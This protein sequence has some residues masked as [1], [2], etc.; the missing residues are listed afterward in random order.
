MNKLNTIMGQ[1][2]ALVSRSRFEKLVREHKAEY[3]SKGLRSWTQFAAMLFG[4]LSGQHGLR[5][6]ET[7]MNSQRNSFYHLGIDGNTEVKR[8]TLSYA[9]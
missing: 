8:S 9:N 1:L 4:Q 3:K 6:I 2:L 5:S 7:G